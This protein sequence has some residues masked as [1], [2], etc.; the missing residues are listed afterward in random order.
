[1]AKVRRSSSAHGRRSWRRVGGSG[2]V[3]FCE[4]VELFVALVVGWWE[5]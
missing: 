3:E 5:R 2:A 1:M 4:C